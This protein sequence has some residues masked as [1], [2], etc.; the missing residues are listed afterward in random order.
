MLE[1]HPQAQLQVF[2]E[3]AGPKALVVVCNDLDDPQLI[4]VQCLFMV[5]VNSRSSLP[6]N[7]PDTRNPTTPSGT[8]DSTS[9]MAS[10]RSKF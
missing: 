10:P 9:I 5:D 7:L 8:S 3:S 1:E 6:A 4:A 2:G